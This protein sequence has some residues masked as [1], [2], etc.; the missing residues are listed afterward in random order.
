MRNQFDTIDFMSLKSR[1]RFSEVMDFFPRDYDADPKIAIE[2]DS[3][4]ES[5]RMTSPDCRMETVRLE[6]SLGLD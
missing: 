5:H 2:T 4:W 6:W 1:H 3:L